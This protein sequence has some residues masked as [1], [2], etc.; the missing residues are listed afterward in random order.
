MASQPALWGVAGLGA[1]CWETAL[2]RAERQPPSPAL[3]PPGPVHRDV[4]LAWVRWN[5]PEHASGEDLLPGSSWMPPRHG[6]LLGASGRSGRSPCGFAEAPTSP[7]RA[8]GPAEPSDVPGPLPSLS[9]ADSSQGMCVCLGTME[10][11]HSWAHGGPLLAPVTPA[12]P[13]WDRHRATRVTLVPPTRGSRARLLNTVAAHHR[14][15][16]GARDASGT[17]LRNF[18]SVRL[19]GGPER[20]IFQNSHSQIFGSWGHTAPWGH[21]P[22]QSKSTRDIWVGCPGGGREHSCDEPPPIHSRRHGHQRE[23][24]SDKV[25]G[26]PKQEVEWVRG[27]KE[28]DIPLLMGTAEHSFAHGL[29]QPILRSPGTSGLSGVSVNPFT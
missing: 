4:W 2:E 14:L 29:S 17:N 15:P 24:A 19:Q 13:Q 23:E 5:E 10:R 11:A 9:L 1:G 22:L 28:E 25:A 8:E 16:E 12:N 20:S 7:L 21:W 26:S 6:A 27:T 3:L 18:N